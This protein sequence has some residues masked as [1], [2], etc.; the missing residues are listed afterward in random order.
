MVRRHRFAKP[1]QVQNQGKEKLHSKKYDG[2]GEGT[3]HFRCLAGG[4]RK[5]AEQRNLVRIGQGRPKFF[6]PL[7]GP[8]GAFL[9]RDPDLEQEGGK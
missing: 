7:Y 4:N 9:K 6:Y 1:V 3:T 8:K 2:E 5:A